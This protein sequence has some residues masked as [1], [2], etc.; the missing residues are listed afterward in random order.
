MATA[1]QAQQILESLAE[2][3]ERIQQ[4]VAELKA[5]APQDDETENL[6]VQSDSREPAG[7]NTGR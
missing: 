3:V 5:T 1:A 2:D 7:A 6:P 4:V